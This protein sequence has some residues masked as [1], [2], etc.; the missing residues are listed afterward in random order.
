[1][2]LHFL[3][4]LATILS[5]PQQNQ[6]IGSV[7]QQTGPCG[8]NI[9][10][11]QNTSVIIETVYCPGI[12]NEVMAF[13][14]KQLEAKNRELRDRDAK[15]KEAEKFRARYEELLQRL[16]AP[17]I[18]SASA[19]EAKKLIEQGKL[20]EAG[21]LLDKNLRDEEK[22]VREDEKQLAARKD[23]F[24]K[25]HYNRALTFQLQLRPREA[26][27]HLEAA[28]T[29]SPDD[30]LYTEG[31]AAGLNDAGEF[32][33]AEPL[34]VSLVSQFRN[35]VETQPAR[36]RP[37][38]ARVLNNL[39]NLYKDTQRFKDSGV[40]YDESISIVRQVAVADRSYE[41]QLAKEL[42]NVALF[43][44]DM[45]KQVRDPQ[46]QAKALA[47]ATEAVSLFRTLASAG[48]EQK[49]DLAVGLINLGV[50]NDRSHK[51][52]ESSAA[53]E[54][55]QQLLRSLVGND[56]YYTLQLATV[57]LDFGLVSDGND[58]EVR[59]EKSSREALEMFCELAERDP[60][61]RHYFVNA[62]LNVALLDKKVGLK[63]QAANDYRQAVEILQELAAENSSAYYGSLGAALHE[64]GTF[65]AESGREPEAEADYQKALTIRRSLASAHPEL[66]LL[67]LAETVYAQ[68]T[69]YLGS[70]RPTQAIAPLEECVGIYRRLSTTQPSANRPDFAACLND[71]ALS[72][73][74]A[75]RVDNLDDA[76]QDLK[77][78]L[79][80]RHELTM[81][82]ATI[83]EP[84]FG[85]TLSNLGLLYMEAN[86][87]LAST[88]F[89]RAIGV[90]RR[91]FKADAN[92]GDDLASAL[93]LA[94]QISDQPDEK[95][96]L[97]KE[98]EQAAHDA[99]LL[100]EARDYHCK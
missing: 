66:Y 56:P 88:Y 49:G 27:P 97:V 61:Y 89:Q 69:F 10:G 6:S 5:S 72:Y 65:Y 54:E 98:A 57:L 63:P 86:P 47:Y 83:Y 94:A 15:L 8:I 48:P 11:T 81:S 34:F 50:I 3:V 30:L 28:H 96:I 85:R 64:R 26:L 29:L 73:L 14:N 68:G 70:K 92:F 2:T 19:K 55:A 12:G 77:Q 18:E 22:E 99:K 76:E 82:D 24:A 78:A 13:F 21:A 45:G 80:I 90:F 59:S 41:N 40:A 20:D 31:L 93:F 51:T 84:D 58:V 16:S 60:A 62:L 1:V 44:S 67:D 35:L 32:E 52:K 39:A 42:S 4:L 87:A 71:L 43:Y 23:R 7:N 95:C 37:A 33:K 91:L 79:S 17:T 100:E 25:D 36:Y 38:L 74:L 46:L 53:Y 9:S 75:N